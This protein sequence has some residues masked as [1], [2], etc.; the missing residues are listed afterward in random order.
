[1]I[2]T[3][4]N[5]LDKPQRNS[6]KNRHKFILRLATEILLPVMA[7]NHVL[8]APDLKLFTQFLKC[9]VHRSFKTDLDFTKFSS[10]IYSK[11]QERLNKLFNIF[12]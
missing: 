5:I 9:F 7:L 2:G 4:P 1:M 12:S 3:L 6:L 11:F 10:Q 8:M